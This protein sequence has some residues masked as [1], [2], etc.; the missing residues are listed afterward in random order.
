[1]PASQPKSFFPLPEAPRMPRRR[2]NLLARVIST[3]GI[4]GVLA[5]LGLALALWNFDLNTYKPRIEAA[6]RADTGRDFAIRGQ[7]S[8]VSW[9]TPT[10]A[11]TDVVFGNLPGTAHPEMLTIPRVEADLGMRALLAGQLDI[12]RL[13]FFAPD[14]RLETAPNGARN[15]RFAPTRRPAAVQP[16]DSAAAPLIVRTLHIKDGRVVWYDPHTAAPTTI[17]VRRLSAT[18]SGGGAAIEWGAD[19]QL[20]SGSVEITGQTGSLVR[21]LQPDAST[22]WNVYLRAT[23]P[24]AVFTL[25]GALRQPW[26]PAGYDLTLDGTL[27]DPSPL[28]S[29]AKLVGATPPTL[30]PLRR[31]AV[32]ARL[33]DA[34]GAPALVAGSLAI[35]PSDFSSLVGGLQIDSA[36]IAAAGGGQPARFTLHGTLGATPLSASGTFGTLANLGSR[37]PLPVDVALVLGDNRVQASGTLGDPATG[38]GADLQLTGRIRDLSAL[39]PLAFYRLPPLLD[40]TATAHVLAAPGGWRHGT[41][42][43]EFTLQLPQGDIAGTLDLARAAA[44]D[45]RPAITLRLRGG[46]LDFDALETQLG[47]YHFLPLPDGPPTAALPF[48]RTIRP[49]I[50]DR[51]FDLAPLRLADAHVALDFGEFDLVGLPFKDLSATIALEGGKLLAEPVRAQLAGGPVE[52]R[53]S[54]DSTIDPPPVALRLQAP[55]LSVRPMLQSIGSIKDITGTLQVDADL[56]A[57][58]RSLHAWAASA[59]GHLA[60]AIVDGSIDNAV[61]VPPFAGVLRVARLPPDLLF[62]PGASRLR[63]FALRLDSSAG[64]ARLATLLLDADRALVQADGT[65]QFGDEAMNLRLRPTLRIGGPGL[66]VPLLLRGSFRSPVLTLDD[67]AVTGDVATALADAAAGRPI[68]GRG[69]LPSDDQCSAALA[70]VRGTAGGLVPGAPPTPF[71]RP[72][73]RAPRR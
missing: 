4:L 72:P 42:V 30:P 39:S 44:P 34:G 3:L 48:A 33:S 54:L 5:L 63:C 1:M 24:G 56:T 65:L 60:A 13:V 11:A 67:A 58:G 9:F 73:P 35:G 23:M 41:V 55:G 10:I 6:I 29:L 47:D 15:W 20:P 71:K 12:A 57:A 49:V 37:L 21:L 19:L 26:R 51:R 66:V 7:L 45:A 22:P 2:P 52:L 8:V 32:E 25:S 17:N 16:E 43:P 50:P 27:D 53:A 46:R 31:I 14:L 64:K 59:S 61:L 40:L 68:P 38:A 36:S 70:V 69:V 28:F 18:R 62:A